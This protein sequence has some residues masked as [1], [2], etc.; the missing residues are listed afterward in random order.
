MKKFIFLVAISLSIFLI[1]F[2]NNKKS[3][4]DIIDIVNFNNFTHNLSEKINITNYDIYFDTLNLEH[5]IMITQNDYFDKSKEILSYNGNS[6]S[7]KTQERLM[8][9]NSNDNHYVFIDFIY[10]DNYIGNNYLYHDY[11]HLKEFNLLDNISTYMISHKN[12]IIKITSIIEDDKYLEIP[13]K[14]LIEIIENLK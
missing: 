2:Y 10:T 3:K 11:N 1:I 5:Y 7:Y 14:F 4:I 6:N 12:I 9:K 13:E 8:Y